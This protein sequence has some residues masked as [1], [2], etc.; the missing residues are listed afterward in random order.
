MEKK[1]KEEAIHTEKI[2]GKDDKVIKDETQIIEMKRMFL[3]IVRGRKETK[4]RK[5]GRKY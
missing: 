2:L 4:R 3:N 1:N 5:R